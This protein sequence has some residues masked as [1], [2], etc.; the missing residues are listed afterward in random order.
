MLVARAHG[1]NGLDRF[2]LALADLDHAAEHHFQRAEAHAKL[3]NRAAA[4]AD[5]LKALELGY[6]QERVRYALTQLAK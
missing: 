3:E 5:Y 6:D 1:H 4:E 2:D